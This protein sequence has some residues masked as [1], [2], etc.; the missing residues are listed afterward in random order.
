M[1][2]MLNVPVTAL[3]CPQHQN[4]QTEL[5]HQPRQLRGYSH[6][7]SQ[8]PAINPGNRPTAHIPGLLGLHITITQVSRSTLSF[9]IYLSHYYGIPSFSPDYS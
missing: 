4:H 1:K 2:I 7:P 8:T 3:T 6:N 9:G 5:L